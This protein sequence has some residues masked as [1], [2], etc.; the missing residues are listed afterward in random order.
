MN[1]PKYTF[2]FSFGNVVTIISGVV[3]AL[4]LVATIQISQASADQERK[5]MKE[6]ILRNETAIHQI[7]AL[8]GDIIRVTVNQENHTK[9]IDSIMEYLK[10]HK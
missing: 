3:F 2:S 6:S 4:G 7:I 1:K 10:E 8:R 5:D 9:Q